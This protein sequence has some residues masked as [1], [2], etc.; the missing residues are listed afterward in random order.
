MSPLDLQGL[1]EQAHLR[2][3]DQGRD[4]YH[5]FGKEKGMS[6][7]FVIRKGREQKAT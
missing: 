3:W 6:H 4:L 5:D 2:G 1:S 7:E